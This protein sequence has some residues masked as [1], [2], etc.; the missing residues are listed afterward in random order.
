MK[1]V[2][3]A[4]CLGLVSAASVLCFVSQTQAAFQNGVIRLHVRANSNSEEDQS[5]KLKVRDAILEEAESMAK[6]ALNTEDAKRIVSSNLDRLKNKAKEEI[7]LQGYN[8]DVRVSYGPSVFPKKEYGDMAF[9]AGTYEAL[10]VEIG[11][12]EGENWWCVMFPPLCFTEEAFASSGEGSEEILIQNLG[13]D[14]YEMTQ[15]GKL[16]I[17]FKIYEIWQGIKNK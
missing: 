17:K 6:S 13:S 12:G 8:Y 7:A 2:V 9:P 14:T 16:Q 3:L 5:L 10:I 15:N 4:M 1:K 11:S